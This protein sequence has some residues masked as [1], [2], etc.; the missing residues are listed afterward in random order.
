MKVLALILCLV[1]AGCVTKRERERIAREAHDAF[2]ERQ[3]RIV[4]E[5]N[6]GEIT[7]SDARNRAIIAYSVLSSTMASS[8][9]KSPWFSSPYPMVRC[10]GCGKFEYTDWE[11]CKFCRWCQ[12]E[13][14]D[15]K[16]W[17]EMKKAGAAW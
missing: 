12:H 2:T 8:L 1:L 17:A 4:A 5:A 14:P 16:Y 9:G 13:W 15:E 11:G 10:I 6:R 7:E 3:D